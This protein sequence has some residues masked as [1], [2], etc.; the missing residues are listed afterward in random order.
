MDVFKRL[1]TKN[2][3]LQFVRFVSDAL[4][5]PFNAFLKLI[6][7]YVKNDGFGQNV[8]LLEHNRLRKNIFER[9]TYETF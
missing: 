6:G 7:L 2:L 5:K 8:D 1:P 4:L 3:R 9:D